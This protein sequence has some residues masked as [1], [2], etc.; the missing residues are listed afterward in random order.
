M[1][2]NYCTLFNSAYLAR[3][4]ALYQSLER[5][6]QNFHLYVFAFDDATRDYFRSNKYN[7]LTVVSLREFEDSELL[8]V[9]SDRTAGEY[10]WTSTSSTILYCIEKFQL[11]HCT[12]LDADMI[13]YA[14]PIVLYNE[15]GNNSVLITE[16]RYTSAYDQSKTSGIYCVQYVTF[17]NDERGMKVLKWW[18]NACLDWCYN[19]LED[20]K[21]GDQKYLDDWTTRFEGVH[22]LKHE[23]GGVAPWNI[24]QYEILIENEVVKLRSKA[25]GVMFSLVFF[26][27]HGLRFYSNDI[28][29]FTGAGYELSRKCKNYLYKP[30]AKMLFVLADKLRH[31]APAV[32]DSNGVTGITRP[33]RLNNFALILREN[34]LNRL[35]FILGRRQSFRK[36]ENHIY[37]R[38]D[39]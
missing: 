15:L 22:V 17:R 3:G 28:V 16:H 18:R 34:A 25:N 31:G 8:R 4:I 33:S 12:Y 24:Q 1:R 30:Y 20:G 5:T 36:S 11:E 9:K 10:C 2:L 27:Y 39:L 13:F 37:S 21:F 26:H 38:S 19:R 7:H 35:R 14:D 6:C 32:S 29:E 23:G